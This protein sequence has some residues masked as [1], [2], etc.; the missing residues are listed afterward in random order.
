[1]ILPPVL[2][3]QFSPI[4]GFAPGEG[5]LTGKIEGKIRGSLMGHG[6][7]RDEP[8]RVWPVRG[9]LKGCCGVPGEK[10]IDAMVITGE[11]ML[12]VQL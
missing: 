5:I 2:H 6:E 1:M 12:P 9:N 7:L 11:L 4:Q 3:S 8:I 10:G